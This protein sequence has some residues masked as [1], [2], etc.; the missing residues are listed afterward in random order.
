MIT[1]NTNTA[2]FYLHDDG[3]VCDAPE[4]NALFGEIYSNVLFDTLEAFLT[5]NI[6]TSIISEDGYKFDVTNDVVFNDDMSFDSLQSAVE[7]LQS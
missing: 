5:T 7:A 1:L 4:S 3:T 2:T 6:V